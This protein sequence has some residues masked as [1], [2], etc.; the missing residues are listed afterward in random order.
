MKY[1]CRQCGK[2]KEACLFTPGAIAQPAAAGP[3]CRKCVADRS[4]QEF[5]TKKLA[6]QKGAEALKRT[7]IRYEK[8]FDRTF[9]AKKAVQN[10]EVQAAVEARK[11]RLESEGRA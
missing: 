10:L 2:S 5:G 3:I 4:G 9:Y 7:V 1:R 6:T 8:Q 11:R